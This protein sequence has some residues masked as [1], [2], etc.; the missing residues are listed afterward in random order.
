[1]FKTLILSAAFILAACGNADSKP[2]E[3]TAKATKSGYDNGYDPARDPAADFIV[4]QQQAQKEGKLILLEVGGNW[5]V[6]CHYLDVFI[7]KDAE[8]KAALDA[9]FVLLKVN[10]G[11]ENPNKEF[12]DT[13]P[14]ISGYP[15][16][17]IADAH[18]KILGTQD[19]A[20]LEEGRSYSKA[21]LLAF[22]KKWTDT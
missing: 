14:K 22:V 15:A 10:T 19:T 4:A 16:F 9:R 20:K 21:A 17:I 11:K 18:G 5:C 13:L 6:W 12:L 1:M 2:V 3:N 7:E 8:V